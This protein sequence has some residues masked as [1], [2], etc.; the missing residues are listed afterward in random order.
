MPNV[1][2]GLHSSVNGKT[3]EMRFIL[4][5]QRPFEWSARSEY[6]TCTQRG[7]SPS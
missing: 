3:A 6:N 7:A 4:G 5:R 1:D 2:T